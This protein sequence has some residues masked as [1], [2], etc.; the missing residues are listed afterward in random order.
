MIKT[1]VQP[2]TPIHY[3]YIKIDNISFGNPSQKCLELINKTALAEDELIPLLDKRPYNKEGHYKI[4]RE[5]EYVTKAIKNNT[6]KEKINEYISFDTEPLDKVFSE[7]CEKNKLQYEKE[8]FAEIIS[9][10]MPLVAKLKY[11]YN[12]PRP[13]TLANIFLVNNK[14]IELYPLVTSSSPSYPSSKTLISYLIT[15][16]I[17]FKNNITREK[18]VDKEKAE[19]VGS[20]YNKVCESSIFLGTHYPTDLKFSILAAKII[21]ENKKFIGKYLK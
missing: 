2:T 18:S 5:L 13:N 7:F 9:D 17:F 21:T 15:K 8:Q 1:L 20:F 6:N 11:Y 12:R 4:I 19:Q 3:G 10:F 14:R 16:I